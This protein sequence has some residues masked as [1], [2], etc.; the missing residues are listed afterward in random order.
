M[1]SLICFVY[2][3]VAVF[4]TN[5]RDTDAGMRHG[6]ADV[7]IQ[8]LCNAENISV[9]LAVNDG[10]P[11]TVSKSGCSLTFPG[12]L[13]SLVLLKFCT[14]ELSGPNLTIVAAGCKEVYDIG[15]CLSVVILRNKTFPPIN[16]QYKDMC[17]YNESMWCRITENTLTDTEP[18]L[19][20]TFYLRSFVSSV[21]MLILALGAAS[22]AVG[23][24]Y[25]KVVEKLKEQTDTTYGTTSS[26]S[27]KD[28]LNAI[29]L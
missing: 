8:R 3:Y 9:S 12:Y 15:V 21:F 27:T 19:L 29:V 2:V 7:A 18:R 6:R 17:Q 23:F 24:C 13:G 20:N 5:P 14:T 28:G 16:F 1:I 10:A 22:L 4:I 25:R 11:N 26:N